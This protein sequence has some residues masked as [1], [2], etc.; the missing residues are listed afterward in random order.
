MGNHHNFCMGRKRVFP[1]CMH[2]IWIDLYIASWKKLNIMT[3]ISDWEFILPA[4]TIDFMRSLPA[5][6]RS[7]RTTMMA[8][9][10]VERCLIAAGCKSIDHSL[11]IDSSKR[12]ASIIRKRLVEEHGCSVFPPGTEE[13]IK[14][15]NMGFRKCFDYDGVYTFI[16]LN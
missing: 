10:Y 15:Y 2:Y 4:E 9:H 8:N 12:L 1:V 6:R 14:K 13:V 16:A 11:D 3:K 7:G 5:R